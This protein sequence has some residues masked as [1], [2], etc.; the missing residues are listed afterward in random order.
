MTAMAWLQRVQIAAALI[1]SYVEEGQ[2]W[3]QSFRRKGLVSIACGP[4]D[5]TANAA[6]IALGRAARR[7]PAVRAELD[8]LFPWLEGQIPKGSYT[9]YEYPLISTWLTLPKL[10][11]ATQKRLAEYK[12]RIEHGHGSD[13]EDEPGYPSEKKS[14]SGKKKSKPD[15]VFEGL[16]L[17]RYAAFCVRRDQILMNQNAGIG[18]AL[19][20]MAGRGAYPELEAL[21]KEFGVKPKAA[22]GMMNAAAAR[23]P[24]W[25]D[26]I[27]K[28]MD[29]QRRFMKA[30]NDAMMTAGGMIQ[31]GSKEAET[32][33]KFQSGKGVD[34]QEYAAQTAAAQ[35]Q[36]AQGGGGDA[37]PTVFP[38][39]KVAKLSDYVGL[40]KG[41]Q[42]GDMMGALKKYGLDMGAYMQVAQA[43][44]AKLA[45]DPMLNAKFSKMLS[46]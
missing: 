41:M 37:D 29:V 42:G 16:T 10:D 26:L 1:I 13:S 7:D 20:A 33:Q 6:V 4:V 34:V 38:G 8:Q 15:P 27:N 23:V 30:K 46:G 45:S 39:Q 28:D 22:N 32:L 2:P 9:S 43:W 18:G 12:D 44:G 3:A 11:P 36:M 19:A 5:W 25:D 24:E 14:K 21:C 31:P 17:D 35:Q 40:I